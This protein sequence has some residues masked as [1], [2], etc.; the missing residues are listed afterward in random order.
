MHLLEPEIIE[1]DTDRTVK[2]H[3]AIKLNISVLQ[4]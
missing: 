1:K 4:K 2:T 3:S